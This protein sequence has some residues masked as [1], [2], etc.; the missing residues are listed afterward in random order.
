MTR[1]S[2]ILVIRFSA[3]GDVALTVPVL[4]EFTQ[5]YPETNIVIASRG[6]FEPFYKDIDNL[7]FHAFEP[8]IKHKGFFGL[9]K[10]FKELKKHDITAVA[11]LHNNLRS[12]VLC[13][14][15]F[16]IGKKIRRLD[17]GRAD[18]KKLTRRF[19]KVLTPLKLTA[20][21]YATV[22]QKLGFPLQLSHQLPKKKPAAISKSLSPLIGVEKT[23]KWIGL[24]PFAQHQQKIYPLVKMEVVLMKLA[25]LGY[26]VF[27]FGGGEKEKAITTAWEVKHH[28]IISIIN[29][30]NLETEL[31]LISHLDLMISMD[32]SGM[33]LAS[34]KGIP[35]ISIWGATHP[36]AGFIGY[37]QLLNDTV[38]LELAC[39]PCSIYGNIPCYRGDFACMNNLS[40]LV[41]I[42]KVIQKL[43]G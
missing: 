5:N 24:S 35:A 12:A 37:G 36:Y 9:L 11:D 14:L 25:E 38:Q 41:V 32:S 13:V 16:M 22:F 19:N 8:K 17:K 2:K 3:M 29:K 6:L 15:F 27:I 42:E 26:K 34:L 20:E 39:R 21:R 10:Y 30:I 7:T 23:Q 28:N 33:H 4:R 18:K 43:N 1:P 40:P 31:E